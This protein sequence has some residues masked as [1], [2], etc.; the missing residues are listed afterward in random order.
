MIPRY[1]RPE[2]AAIWSPQTRF[3]IMFEIEAHAADAMAELG[4]IPVEAARAIWEKAGSA[5][6]DVLVVTP[7]GCAGGHDSI[8]IRKRA[9][10]MLAI[11]LT[12]AT[13]APPPD[14]GGGDT[15]DTPPFPCCDPALRTCGDNMTC[16]VN[17]TVNQGTCTAAGTGGHGSACN[18]DNKNCQP[19]TQC[20]DYAGLGCNVTACLKFCKTNGD[21]AN[22]TDGGDLTNVTCTA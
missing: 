20:F 21:C 3:R 6:F 4:V 9:V 1:S 17:C 12:P 14:G 10:A 2:A 11:A 7:A 22:V 5:V 19:G 13:C 16:H 15:V 8:P 18:N